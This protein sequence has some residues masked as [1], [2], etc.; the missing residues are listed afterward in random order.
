MQQQKEIIEYW[1]STNV[2]A[3]PVCVQI[4]MSERDEEKAKELFEE[5]FH[6][7]KSSIIDKPTGGKFLFLNEVWEL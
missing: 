3:S 1:F 6:P 7:V 2:F 4:R 5:M